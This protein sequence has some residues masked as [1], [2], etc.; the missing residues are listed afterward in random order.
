ML[1]PIELAA[2]RFDPDF[3]VLER[4]IGLRTPIGEK[5]NRAISLPGPPR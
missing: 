3:R 2:R 4:R 1:G 5:G